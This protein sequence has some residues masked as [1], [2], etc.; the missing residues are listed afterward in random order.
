MGK[1]FID[2][3]NSTK[4]QLVHVPYKDSCPESE[5]TLKEISKSQVKE[6]SAL[7]DSGIYY[8]DDYDYMKHLKEIKEENFKISSL[9]IK[10]LRLDDYESRNDFL[11][12]EIMQVLDALEDEEYL[13]EEENLTEFFQ[14]ISISKQYE[15]KKLEKQDTS[16]K[17]EKQDASKKVKIEKEM[18]RLKRNSNLQI[19]DSKFDKILEKEYEISDSDQDSENLNEITSDLE[20]IFEEFLENI[21][22]IGKKKKVIKKRDKLDISVLENLHLQD[23]S[24]DISLEEIPKKEEWDCE[25]ILST[26]SNIYNRPRVLKENVEKKISLKKLSNVDKSHNQDKSVRVSENLGVKRT[27]NET[28]EEKKERKQDLKSKRRERRAVKKATTRAF[29][30]EK[31]KT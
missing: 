20:E 1:G 10:D 25:T 14:E 21:E 9:D 19:L 13:E 29:L 26:F 3:K 12:E 23:S 16:K 7:Q 31:L 17:L 18:P 6:T 28:L 5:F 22:T 15:T 2:K 27:K 11:D 24:S 4:Y 30:E 8:N